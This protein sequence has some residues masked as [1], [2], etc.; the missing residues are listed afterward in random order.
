MNIKD[1]KV[2]AYTFAR[3][4]YQYNSCKPYYASK[5]Q[6]YEN[7]LNCD[8]AMGQFV[9]DDYNRIKKQAEEQDFAHKYIDIDKCSDESDLE[10]RA[11][12]KEDHGNDYVILYQYKIYPIY[13]HNIYNILVYRGFIIY[14][15]PVIADGG[16]K[17][18]FSITN[19]IYESDFN[20]YDSICEAIDAINNL[21]SYMNTI[22]NNIFKGE[23][24]K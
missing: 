13:H 8:K 16:I 10:I 2:T 11:Y 24:K 23:E 20:R 19:D 3:Y 4:S 5:T 17:M 6:I 1:L 15:V 9:K 12:D 21:L 14:L 7:Q 22:G 18:K